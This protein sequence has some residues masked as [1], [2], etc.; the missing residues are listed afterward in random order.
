MAA[1]K[2]LLPEDIKPMLAT[3]VDKPF[4]SEG[5]LYEVKWDGYRA[6]AYLH[7]GSI[8]IKS[9]NNKSFNDKFYPLIAALKSWK[10]N[11]ILDG[12][13]VVVN[14]KGFPDFG[15]L[16]NWRSEADGHLAFYV[17]D[18]L[19]YDGMDKM[20][21][22][23]TERR[24]LLKKILPDHP[25]IKLSETFEASGSSFFAIAEKMQ[26]EGIMAKKADSVYIP[27]A[28]S[29][30]W[31][32]I[33]TEKRQEAIICG[34][35][36]NE[37]TSKPFS[38][39]LLG[40]YEDDEL[41]SIGPVGTG[42]SVQQQKDMLK[43]FAPLVIKKC[44]FK[45]VP[46]FNKPSRF[47]PNPPKAVAVWLKPQIVCEI[48][49][50]ELTKDKALRHPSFKGL[51]EDKSA[52]E[53]RWE[54]PANIQTTDVEEELTNKKMISSPGQKQR[55]TLLNPSEESQVRRIGGHD[56]KFQNLSKVYWPK[57][58]VTKRDMLNYYYQVAPY[59]LPYLKDRPQTLNRYPNGITGKAFYQRDVKGKVPGWIRTEP[60]TDSDGQNKEVII[61]NDEATLLYI[62]AMGCIEINAWSSTLK[63]PGNPNWCIIDLDPDKNT[64]NQVIEA[65]RLTKDILD[66]IGV[67]SF[68][69]TSGSTGLHIYIP[70]GAKYTYEDSKEFGRALATILHR[71]IPKFTSIERQTKNRGGKMYIDFLQN[72]PQATVAS[73]YSLRPKPGAPV[74]MPL[75]WD[76]VKKGLKILDFTIFNA[77]D[78]IKAEGDIFKG[79]LGKGINLKRA[80]KKIEQVFLTS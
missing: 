39:L 12:E 9:R 56:V 7:K 20:H 25:V 13:I 69:K 54:T 52:A 80:L 10:V 68:C 11:A 72:R 50:R 71:Q 17:F 6:L 74:S 35:T 45:T 16:Q 37:N 67:E 26:L 77:M 4:D 51:R 61:C 44:P 21:L 31:L 41:I 46:D 57:E 19:W 65:A 60:Y 66:A 42:F 33:K 48:S 14:D 53:I 43:R 59:I 36:I 27:G 64:F 23:L 22:P 75:H 2:T 73:V 49:Y 58:K 24:A 5:W 34:Y 32:K 40:L 3:L 28:R 1:K 38:A 29:R 18:I 15:D 79:V 30:D 63:K 70:F 76:E 62:A 78:R 8:D 47:R 55:N